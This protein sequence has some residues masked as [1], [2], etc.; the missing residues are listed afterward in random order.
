MG[1]VC[2][3]IGAGVHVRYMPGGV[4]WRDRPVARAR[5][6]EWGYGCWHAQLEAD[7]TFEPSSEEF[8]RYAPARKNAA[9]ATSMPPSSACTRLM[10]L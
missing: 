10:Q 3:C 8:E 5:V 4:H 6:G 2:K 9:G 7:A 1:V